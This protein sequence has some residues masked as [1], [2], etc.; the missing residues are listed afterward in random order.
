MNG[1]TP[2]ILQNYSLC[3]HKDDI[4]LYHKNCT[5]CY[6]IC[7]EAYNTNSRIFSNPEI[8]KD[9]VNIVSY[10]KD[11]IIYYMPLYLREFIKLTENKINA[12]IPENYKQ[13]KV[14]CAVRNTSTNEDWKI[15][16]NCKFEK[17][18]DI[19]IEKNEIIRIIVRR[20]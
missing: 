18:A 7:N 14:T 5:E 2:H 11:R 12:F 15:Y 17:Y 19:I 9:L 16:H 1:Q 10:Q 8:K 13:Y 4:S 20:L 3:E 6:V